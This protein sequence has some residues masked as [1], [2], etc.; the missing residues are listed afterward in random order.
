MQDTKS[1][2]WPCARSSR[3]RSWLLTS[4]ET[5]DKLEKRKDRDSELQRHSLAKL[6]PQAHL[7][8]GEKASWVTAEGIL[9]A[10]VGRWG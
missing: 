9:R 1:P 10:C 7:T 3:V 8:G 4:K 5:C 6:G 2:S